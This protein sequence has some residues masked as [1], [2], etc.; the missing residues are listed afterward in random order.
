M[1]HLSCAVKGAPAVHNE[2]QAGRRSVNKVMGTEQRNTCMMCYTGSEL[3][4]HRARE[5]VE[6]KGAWV[7]HRS[8]RS[9]LRP[10]QPERSWELSSR[11]KR[12]N[13]RPQ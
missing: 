3:H 5:K 10:P 6:E 4:S 1:E 7:P 13:Q 8:T 9:A 2:G 12:V 11:E